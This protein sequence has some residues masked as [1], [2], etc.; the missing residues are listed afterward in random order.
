MPG[1]K[2]KRRVSVPPEMIRNRLRPIEQAVLT[3]LGLRK[4][5]YNR[6]QQAVYTRDC[7]SYVMWKL[8][9]S[10]PKIGKYW[11]L[12]HASI[13]A[14]VNKRIPR[15]P[16]VLA[17][18]DRIADSLAANADLTPSGPWVQAPLPPELAEAY[19]GSTARQ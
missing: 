16:A 3:E 11:D 18:L 5:G 9:W 8:G 2:P 7:I 13:Y 19:N 10:Y 6:T 1:H 12:D 4:P 17:R 15:R 14:G